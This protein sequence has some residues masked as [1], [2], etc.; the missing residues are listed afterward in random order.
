V[1]KDIFGNGGDDH[2]DHL[3]A[4]ERPSPGDAYGER[5]AGRMER[6]KRQTGRTRPRTAMAIAFTVVAFGMIA[7]SGG[8]SYA[9]EGINDAVTGGS[10]EAN[11]TATASPADVQY[12][13]GTCVEDVNPHGSTVPPAGQTPPG[14]GPGENEDGFYNV[15]SSDGSSVIVT[16]LGS[17]Q[18]FG[19]YPSGT[20]IKYTQ[21]TGATPSEKTIG[22]TTGQ[23]GAVLVHITGTGDFSVTP[24]GGGTSTTCLVPR[25][26][27]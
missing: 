15:G 27:K 6:M 9:V 16:D 25:P 1:E 2:I 3:L 24:V 23:A 19:P 4:D 21:A 18:T 26:P 17:G 14:N 8:V 12:T 5:F 11:V 20:V 7:A 10:T 13:S 22:S